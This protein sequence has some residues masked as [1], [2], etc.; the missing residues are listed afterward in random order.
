MSSLE[1]IEP[2][3]AEFVMGKILDTLMQPGVMFKNM[4][5]VTTGSGIELFIVILNSA[6]WGGFGWLFIYLIR[7]RLKIK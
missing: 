3:L 1:G 7:K 6:I 5:G 4:I 2:T